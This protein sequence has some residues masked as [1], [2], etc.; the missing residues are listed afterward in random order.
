MDSKSIRAK[1]KEFMLPAV[2]NYYEEPVVPLEGK[3]SRLTD[4]A[5][6]SGLTKQALVLVTV[7]GGKWQLLQD[8]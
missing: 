6:S 2:A 5:E 4:L 8:K 3:G 1:H 7:S